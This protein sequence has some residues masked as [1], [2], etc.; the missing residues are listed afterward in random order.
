M[1]VES[2]GCMLGEI[3]SERRG[4]LTLTEV[5][6]SILIGGLIQFDIVDALNDKF[7]TTLAKELVVKTRDIL[8]HLR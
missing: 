7:Q 5:R 1:H 2:L 3:R 8:K 6:G 4:S